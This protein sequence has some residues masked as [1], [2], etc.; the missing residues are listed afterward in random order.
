M[1]IRK[2]NPK[3][4]EIA[5]KNKRTAI[6]LYKAG[7][8]DFEDPE[9]DSRCHRKGVFV[10]SLRGKGFVESSVDRS[11]RLKVPSDGDAR[12]LRTAIQQHIY[13]GQSG[14]DNSRDEVRVYCNGKARIIAYM[15]IVRRQPGF[16]MPY[17]TAKLKALCPAEVGRIEDAL[18]D[19]RSPTE[20][21]I[22]LVYYPKPKPKPR[23]LAE[24][25]KKAERIRE[26]AERCRIA[27][28]K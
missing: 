1:P 10:S 20:P 19:C 4:P 27:L 17:D 23:E 9:S 21:L 3:V 24:S 7:L 2:V 5:P 15:E 18:E 12:Y 28:S 22:R 13:N 6:E 16:E 11:H 14:L 25:E 8:Y 26:L